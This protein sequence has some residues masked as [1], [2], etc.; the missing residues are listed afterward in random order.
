MSTA[1]E[2]PP[3]LTIYTADSTRQALLSWLQARPTQA[4]SLVSLQEA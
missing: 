3:E 4:A 2:L 1:F